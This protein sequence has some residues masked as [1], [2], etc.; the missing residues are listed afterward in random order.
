MPLGQLTSLPRPL[1]VNPFY[2]L[3]VRFARVKMGSAETLFTL[4][5]W[6]LRYSWAAFFILCV[7]VWLPLEEIDYVSTAVRLLTL[8][9]PFFFIW[10]LTRLAGVELMQ[11]LLEA[12]WTSEVLASPLTDRDLTNG[13]V[14][15]VWVVVRQY[16]LMAFFSLILYTLEQHVFVKIDDEW[17]VGDLARNAVFY[18]ALFFSTI[19]WLVFLYISRLWIE[20]RLRSGLLKGLSTLALLIAGSVLFLGYLGLFFIWQKHVTST[21][22]LVGFA[23]LAAVLIAAALGLNMKLGRHFRSYLLGQLDI[24]PLVYDQIDPRATAW[25][26]HAPSSN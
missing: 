7:M 26:T 3:M 12:H 18:E 14:M 16:C 8:L 25:T 4:E 20:V 24:D 15:P 13:F 2:P 21:P 22:V 11:L 10:S 5:N 17:I 6:L 9:Y 1:A 19:A 23:V